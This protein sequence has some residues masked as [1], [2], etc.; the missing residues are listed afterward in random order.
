MELDAK[1]LAVASRPLRARKDY[2]H[3]TWARTYHCRP[4]FYIQPSS[5]DEIEQVVNAA[6]QCRRR[7]TT[8]GSGH[9]PSDL[10]CTSS[11]AV[12][13]DKFNRVL[14]VD[15]AKAIVTVQSGIRL[16]DL[17]DRLGK[18][19]LSL[20]NLGSIDDQ[21]I[22]GAIATGTH[23]SSLAHG[24][25]SDTIT[26]LKIMLANGE[27]KV[28]SREQD[29][30]LFRAALV[31]LGALGI[32]IEITLQAVP[33]FVL[34]WEQVIGTDSSMLDIWHTTLW[35][36]ATFVRVW[37]FPYTQ[38]A[39]IWTAHETDEQPREASLSWYEKYV[40]YY[41]H[42]NLLYA[43]Q[44]VPRI[45]PWIEWFIFGMQ[46]GFANGSKT[47]GIQPGRKALLMDCLY[48]QTVN[49]W[50]IPLSKGPE[51]LRRLSTWL[52]QL[53]KSHPTYME[54]KIPF[55]N[56]GLYVHAPLEVRVSDTSRR[57]PGDRP[58]LDPTCEMEPTLYL[59]A[60][61]YRPYGTD[62]PCRVRYYEAFE[63]LMKDLGGRP[64]WAKNFVTTGDDVEA[65]YGEQL[66]QWRS[67]RDRVDPDGM[68]A[69]TWHRRMV[70]GSGDRLALEEREIGQR[71]ATGGGIFVT[72]EVSSKAA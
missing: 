72:G 14:D 65:M 16:H 61:S 52:N 59:N 17:G 4:E 53:D 19:G 3:S 69:G 13:L 39:T 48:S 54:S 21:S 56:H 38:R 25:L 22:A 49:E 45:L 10:T 44:S 34:S 2:V 64:H 8:I 36:Q 55:D 50:A 40:A 15:K 57:A 5:I 29:V 24:L 63:W 51:A 20:P 70:L 37:W 23:G 43:A 11:W 35:K 30:E 33:A 9:S 68:F 26:S 27:V 58:Y 42:L 18:H 41:V 28:C 62:P 1:S 12:N 60:T 46:H 66:Q 32:V 7:I 47:S 67:V 6:R 31:S 71:P